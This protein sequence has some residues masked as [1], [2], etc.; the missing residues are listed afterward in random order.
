MWVIIRY[1]DV[2]LELP[3]FQLSMAVVTRR[4]EVLEEIITPLAPPRL[5]LLVVLCP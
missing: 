3:A 2:I 1:T 5:V 4:P